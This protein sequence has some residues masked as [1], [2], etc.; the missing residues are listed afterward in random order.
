[1]GRRR[2]RAER[3]GARTARECA[4]G[5]DAEA[6]VDAC[7]LD[8][9][10]QRAAIPVVALGVGLTR[11][12]GQRG[13]RRRGWR[14]TRRAELVRQRAG[15]TG[16]GGLAGAL[17]LKRVEALRALAGTVRL[18]AH[19]GGTPLAVVRVGIAVAATHGG[20]QVEADR[21]PHHARA[22]RLATGAWR[23]LA[24]LVRL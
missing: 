1:R 4:L 7:A 19:A 2:W 15:L 11:L 13:A 23:A 16:R 8:A 17:P 5:S 9:A 14:T 22:A 20:D 21:R 24:E 12:I 6:L 10:I 3:G 18:L